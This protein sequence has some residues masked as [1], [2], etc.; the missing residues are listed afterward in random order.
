MWRV[1]DDLCYSRSG[2]GYSFTRADVEDMTPGEAV[3]YRDRLGE[4]LKAESEA[5]KAAAARGRRR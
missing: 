1:V 2:S 3:F 4:H 5:I